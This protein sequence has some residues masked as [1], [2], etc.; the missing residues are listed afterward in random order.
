MSFD[1]HVRSAIQKACGHAS[2]KPCLTWLSERLPMQVFQMRKE[3][4]ALR[5]HDTAGGSNVCESGS[6][7]V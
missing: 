4:V 5:S 6:K 7:R 2:T 3:L 1:V